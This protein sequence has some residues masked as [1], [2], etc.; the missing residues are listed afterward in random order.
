MFE[1]GQFSVAIKT[2]KRTKTLQEKTLALL[3]RHG[4]R[5]QRITLF[6]ASREEENAYRNTSFKG[7]IYVVGRLGIRPTVTAYR[8][9]YE[10]GARVLHMDDDVSDIL[11]KVDDKTLAPIEDLASYVDNM[12]DITEN[13]G[14]RL[15]GI[16]SAANALFMRDRVQRGL[17][18]CGGFF[19]GFISDGGKDES[20]LPTVNFKDDVEATLAYYTADGATV[21]DDGVTGRT[22][23]FRQGGGG[24]AEHARREVE[25]L[26]DVETLTSKYPGLCYPKETKNFGGR[27]VAFRRM[28][29]NQTLCP[30]PAVVRRMNVAS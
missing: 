2:F 16:Y 15:W 24:T 5:D 28:P 27:D 18:F 19:H 29:N 6:V 4:I 12:F 26:Q 30:S 3:R 17:K 23:Y 22:A 14:C 25:H 1:A 7:D 20:L 8:K 9:H 13:V 11:K 21:R 10:A